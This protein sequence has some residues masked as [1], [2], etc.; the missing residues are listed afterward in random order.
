[1]VSRFIFVLLFLTCAVGN[2]AEIVWVELTPMLSYKDLSTNCKTDGYFRHYLG[3]EIDDRE[4]KAAVLKAGGLEVFHHGI[5]LK[6]QELAGLQFERD[7]FERAWLTGFALSERLIRWVL[8]NSGG[9]LDGC[10]PS[11]PLISASPASFPF[12]FKLESVG[13]GPRVLTSNFGKFGGT[14]KDGRAYQAGIYFIQKQYKDL[15]NP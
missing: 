8:E 14:R 9:S 10:T 4:V 15:V 6:D 3:A 12:K 7:T 11:Q 13:A 2:S 1:M 5:S